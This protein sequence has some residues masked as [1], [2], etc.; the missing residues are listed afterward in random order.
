MTWSENG[1][2]ADDRPADGL[3]IPMDDDL[4]SRL[5]AFRRQNPDFMTIEEATRHILRLWL[6]ENGYDGLVHADA[7]RRPDALN[8]SNDD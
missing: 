7:G 5:A 1:G 2:A 8:A 4:A 6:T 3:T